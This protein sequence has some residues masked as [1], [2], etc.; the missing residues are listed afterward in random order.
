MEAKGQKALD[1]YV[2]GSKVTDEIKAFR[3]AR[4]RCDHQG[5]LSAKKNWQSFYD[6]TRI[7]VVPAAVWRRRQRKVVEALYNGAAIVTTSVGSEGIPEA[8][9]P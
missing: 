7:V 4:Q 9:K 8:W 2:V 3:A 5:A 1:F 6:T